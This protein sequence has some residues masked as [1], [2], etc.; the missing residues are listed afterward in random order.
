MNKTYKILQKKKSI[1][2][3]RYT[4]F[5]LCLTCSLFD[6]ISF[7]Y[8]MQILQCTKYVF[9]CGF[10]FQKTEDIGEKIFRIAMNNILI[11]LMVTLVNILSEGQKK[12]RNSKS[13]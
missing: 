2:Y 13:S 9:V 6:K 7:A 10:F 12:F 1:F 5:A 8:I 11:A 3:N 4:N